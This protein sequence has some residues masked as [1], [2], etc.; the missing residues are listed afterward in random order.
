MHLQNLLG[1][2][3]GEGKSGPSVGLLGG[4]KL[5]MRET[6]PPSVVTLTGSSTASVVT[7]TGSSTPSVVTLTGSSTPSVVTRIGISPLSEVPGIPTS[8][9]V[10]VSLV[11]RRKGTNP[12]ALQLRQKGT[13]LCSED[14]DVEGLGRVVIKVSMVELELEVVSGSSGSQ[15]HSP[16][17][18]LHSPNWR[19]AGQEPS[20]TRM[21]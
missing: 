17:P 5:V 4:P 12:E 6:S 11:P 9:V 20:T 1:G 19:P 7:L 3:V 8:T 14:P 2:F 16:A 21:L 13:I 15:Q 10:D 18:S